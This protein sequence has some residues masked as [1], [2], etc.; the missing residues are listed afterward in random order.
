MDFF[1]NDNNFNDNLINTSENNYRSFEREYQT[2]L[3]KAL[4]QL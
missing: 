4:K 1:R 2:Q 3:Q